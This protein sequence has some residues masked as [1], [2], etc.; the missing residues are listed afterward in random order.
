MDRFVRGY[1]RRGKNVDAFSDLLQTDYDMKVI[2]SIEVANQIQRIVEFIDSHQNVR[3]VY[4]IIPDFPSLSEYIQFRSSSSSSSKPNENDASQEGNESKEGDNEGGGGGDQNT[5]RSIKK[6]VRFVVS[7]DEDEETEAEVVDLEE[8]DLDELDFDLDDIPP[9]PPPLLTPPPPPTEEEFLAMKEKEEETEE[10]GRGVDQ[11]VPSPPRPS[12]RPT[13]SHIVLDQLELLDQEIEKEKSKKIL[14][15]EATTQQNQDSTKTHSRFR[16]SIEI[17]NETDKMHDDDEQDNEGENLEEEEERHESQP[18]SEEETVSQSEELQHNQQ[19]ESSKDHEQEI[20]ESNLISNNITISPDSFSTYQH[21]E[22]KP[23]L[24]DQIVLCGDVENFIIH[25]TS[26]TPNN[27]EMILKLSPNQSMLFNE[28]IHLR[29]MNGFID[30]LVAEEKDVPPYIVSVYEDVM[31]NVITYQKL[32]YSG[33]LLEKGSELNMLQ[34]L[35]MNC[36]SMSFEGRVDLCWNVVETVKI[37]HDSGKVWLDCQLS[38]FVH[39][40]LCEYTQW[41]AIDFEHSLNVRENI[42]IFH[43]GCLSHYSPPELLRR[44]KGRMSV[45][46]K[47]LASKS[48]DMWNVGVCMLEIMTGRSFKQNLGFLPTSSTSSSSS[49]INNDISNSPSMASISRSEEAFDSLFLDEDTEEIEDTI[50]GMI[51]KNLM[52]SEYVHFKTLLSQCLEID[53]QS[54]I[55][56]F[57]CLKHVYFKNHE[58]F[59]ENNTSH[60][61]MRS[62]QVSLR[63]SSTN[64]HSLTHDN[65]PSTTT[66]EAKNKNKEEEEEE[67]Y[68][69]ERFNSLL[70]QV[71]S[72][73]SILSDEQEDLYMDLKKLYKKKQRNSQPRG[74]LMTPSSPTTTTTTNSSQSTSSSYDREI[75][76]CCNQLLDILKTV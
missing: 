36:Q 50:L 22:F 67:E 53:F 24:E 68:T 62:S 59:H 61:R 13:P 44:L 31:E 46:R 40:P 52:N 57:E 49:N 29:D 38:N 73:L 9:P 8:L 74:D 70:L 19:S 63:G 14:E 47:T 37:I 2:E 55:T 11:E 35:H 58:R 72:H 28:Y 41:K 17:V 23:S 26:S 54:R 45:G 4:F 75:E 3:L 69:L 32:P 7:F 27:Q 76:I 25:T 5:R 1:N 20:E 16:K 43:G 65:Q 18:T 42:T 12:S 30:G 34:Y 56:S 21:L 60:S 66:N 51:S 10:A 64:R 6:E 48:M 71:K 15:E 39:F 33:I